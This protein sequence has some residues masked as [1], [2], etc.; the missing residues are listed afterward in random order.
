[1]DYNPFLFILCRDEESA[2][3]LFIYININKFIYIN[4]YKNYKNIIVY[5]FMYTI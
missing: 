5:I 3:I 2:I 4:G 1:M